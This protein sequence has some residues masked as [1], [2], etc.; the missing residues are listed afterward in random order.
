MKKCDVIYTLISEVVKS[1]IVGQ[2]QV[3]NYNKV[4]T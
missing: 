2:V 1:D 4:S 3:S